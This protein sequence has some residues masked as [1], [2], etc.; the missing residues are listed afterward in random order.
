MKFLGV[1]STQQLGEYEE[2]SQEEQHVDANA[3]AILPAWFCSVVQEIS[4]VI[5]NLVIFFR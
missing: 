1:L 2:E 4:Q 5:N 3:L